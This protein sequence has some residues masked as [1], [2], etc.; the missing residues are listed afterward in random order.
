MVFKAAPNPNQSIIVSHVDRRDLCTTAG[1]SSSNTTRGEAAW[2]LPLRWTHRR[3]IESWAVAFCE[4]RD[5]VQGGVAE[6]HH[7]CLNCWKVSA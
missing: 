3:R 4:G 6:W 5:G 7:L 1:T 2:E